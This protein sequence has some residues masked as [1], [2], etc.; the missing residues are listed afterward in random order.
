MVPRFTAI[1][2]PK[3]GKRE[4]VDLCTEVKVSLKGLGTEICIVAVA[5]SS[6]VLSSA[7][8]SLNRNKGIARESQ[9]PVHMFKEF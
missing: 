9:R 5:S 6:I 4:N 1:I 8:T 7:G 2:Q 3:A